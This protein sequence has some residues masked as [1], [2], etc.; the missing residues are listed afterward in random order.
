MT[1]DS[2]ARAACATP[3]DPVVLMDYWLG[4][5]PLDEEERLEAHLF[6]CDD[7]GERLRHQMALAEG[8]RALARSGTLRVVITE[9]VLQRAAE[10]GQQI[11]EY[12]AAPGQIV[13]CTVSADDDRLVARLS[14]DLSGAARVDFT[15]STT[16]GVELQRLPDIAVRGDIVTVLYQE[17][18][19]FAKAAPDNR[20]V[21]RLITV[22]TVGDE[23]VLGEYTFHHTRTIPGPPDWNHPGRS[24]G[25]GDGA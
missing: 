21:M 16:D 2:D 9:S 12:R 11:R 13:P 10:S 18:I 17:S 3:A 19:A 14:A 4:L 8:L 7:C 15:V 24:E 20:V 25:R 1:P 23:R 22:D 6:E 5:L